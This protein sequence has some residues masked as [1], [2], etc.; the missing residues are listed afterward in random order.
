MS[1]DK[2]LKIQGAIY[3]NCIKKALLYKQYNGNLPDIRLF[4]GKNG[5][6]LIA[7]ANRLR[8][9]GAVRSGEIFTEF[10]DLN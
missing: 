7:A 6:L 2:D 9:A 5:I 4:F 1:S 3:T 8:P 10:P